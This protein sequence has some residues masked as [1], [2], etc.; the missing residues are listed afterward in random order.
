V[1]GAIDDGPAFA[2]NMPAENSRVA[3]H[4][5]L[6]AWTVRRFGTPVAGRP[7][8]SSR[9]W[10]PPRILSTRTV[11]RTAGQ[12]PWSTRGY[13]R[14]HSSAVESQSSVGNI[15]LSQGTAFLSHSLA[16]GYAHLLDDPGRA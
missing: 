3:V 1:E 11:P 12:F 16:L 6:P 15:D 7:A 14:G 4:V 5:N 2:V 10:K 9:S 13:A 8:R